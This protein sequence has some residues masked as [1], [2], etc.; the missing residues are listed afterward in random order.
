MEIAL[1]TTTIHVPDVLRLYRQELPTAHI[2]VAGDLA[3]PHN[4]VKQLV[5]EVGG[6]YLHPDD[7][8]RFACSGPIGWNAVERRNIALLRAL[9]FDPDVI[10]TVDDDNYPLPGYGQALEKAFST[11]WGYKAECSTPV[12]D[13]GVLFVPPYVQR[14]A[15]GGS[16]SYKLSVAKRNPGIVQG[17]V[18]GEPD[19]AAVE[20]LRQPEATV[21]NAPAL[22][23]EGIAFS[24]YVPVNTQNTAFLA[25][26]APYFP[27]LP[28]TGRADDIWGGFI[29][30]RA[31]REKGYDTLLGPPLAWQDRNQHDITDDYEREILCNERSADFINCLEEN[32]DL[33]GCMVLPDNTRRFIVSWRKDVGL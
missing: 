17:V 30:Q 13:Y 20:R 19:R 29:A 16:R 12:F 9:E 1:I 22:L 27:C 28:H 33:A 6:E 8:T 10:V 18:L 14:G 3:T 31:A 5:T 26:L 7:Q 24:S 21:Q 2:V 15:V 23:M 32:A 25:E 4:L 11:S